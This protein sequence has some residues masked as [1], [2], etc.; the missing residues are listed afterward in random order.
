M[1]ATLAKLVKQ[2]GYDN[3]LAALK[4][5]EPNTSATF[6]ATDFDAAF[7]RCDNERGSNFVNLVNLR[8]EANT[9]RKSFDAVLETVRREYRYTMSGAEGR[10]GITEEE[11][12]ASIKEHG[13]TLLYVSRR[14]N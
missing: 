12:A 2:M 13:E 5:L 10:F 9:D 4:S 8:R 7:Q 3:V 11:R 14:H 1:N 6:T